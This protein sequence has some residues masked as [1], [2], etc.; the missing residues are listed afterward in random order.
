MG[1]DETAQTKS[2][3][4]PQNADAYYNR[5]LTQTEQGLY[6]QAVENCN[7]AMSL[8]RDKSLTLN[9]LQC[10]AG[11]YAGLEDDAKALEDASKVLQMDPNN[12]VMLGIRAT[13]YADQKKLNEAMADYNKIISLKPASPEILNATYSGR[14][15]LREDLKQFQ[16]QV[17]DA[18]KAISFD[19][20]D[21][22]S[23]SLRGRGNF[24]LKKFELAIIDFTRAIQLNP[25]AANYYLERAAAYTNAGKKDLAIADTKTA[26]KLGAN[27]GTAAGAGK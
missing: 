1:V 13:L 24:E 9:I 20:N 5:A 19:P 15:G 21:Y 6:K 3:G 10:R 22:E 11:A 23:Y 14:A 17:E 18:S 2:D 25:K 7:R 12:V 4:R 8:S 27:V 16:E 26:A